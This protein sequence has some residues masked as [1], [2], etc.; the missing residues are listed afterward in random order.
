MFQT[1][2]RSSLQYL[3]PSSSGDCVVVFGRHVAEHQLHRNLVV[4]RLK[5]LLGFTLQHRSTL[6][7]KLLP[8]RKEW[9]KVEPPTTND[10][11]LEP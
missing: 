10:V 9:R 6:D 7:R 5:G 11:R 4:S 2:L 3:T 8:R 1:G